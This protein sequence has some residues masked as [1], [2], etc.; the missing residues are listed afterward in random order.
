MGVN[1]LCMILVPV[2]KPTFSGPRNPM[3]LF[4]KIYR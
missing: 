4:S 2:A 3:V 1:D